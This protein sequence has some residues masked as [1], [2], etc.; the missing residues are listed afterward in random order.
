M[1]PNGDTVGV[2]KSGGGGISLLWFFTGLI[3]GAAVMVVAAYFAMQN[4]NF[5]NWLRNYF[6]TVSIQQFSQINT[7]TPPVQS[8]KS[9]ETASTTIAVPKAYATQD[10]YTAINN[11]YFDYSNMI[12]VGGQIAPLFAKLNTQTASGDYGGVI[13]L[14][15][16]IKQLISK[17][18]EI[19]NSFGQHLVSLS[20]ANQGS[21]DPV[22]KS[23]TQDI[24]SSGNVFR[25]GV[26]PYFDALDGIFS[27]KPPTSADIAH[28]TTLA[29]KTTENLT[30]FKGKFQLVLNHFK[31]AAT[32]AH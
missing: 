32:A 26:A 2:Q 7:S 3:V 5:Q 24:I 8:L 22:T 11:V 30:D 25:D 15:V 20:V 19:A 21:K 14:A 18:K 1:P 29:Q 31:D 27:G 17:E 28:V 12:Q 16:Q 13:D 9:F 6:V 23:L 4:T 10:Y